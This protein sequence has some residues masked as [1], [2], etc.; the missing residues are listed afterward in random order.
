MS[1]ATAILTLSAGALLTVVTGLWIMLEL[2][3]F[4]P[5]VGGIIVFRPDTAAGERWSVRAAVAEPAAGVMRESAH[6]VLSPAAMAQR[7]GSLV[8]EARRM[9]RPPEYRVHWAGGPTDIGGGDCGARADLVL[10]RT[11][12]MRL[13][14][15]AGG[16]NS[17]MRLIGP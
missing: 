17:G 6:C 11:E 2:E 3:Q 13:A 5:A 4:G 9:S 16:F 8:V 15:V 10:E 1:L 12:L 14:N 7:G